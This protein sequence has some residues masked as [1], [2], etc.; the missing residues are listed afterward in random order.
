MEEEQNQQYL[1]DPNLT[2][3]MRIQIAIDEFYGFVKTF[4]GESEKVTK[5]KL[6]RNNILNMTDTYLKKFNNELI[7]EEF[8]ER[9]S[10]AK[11]KASN[12]GKVNKYKQF[13][14]ELRVVQEYKGIQQNIAEK[15]AEQLF[16]LFKDSEVLPDGGPATNDTN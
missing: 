12:N 16:D 8:R 10:D 7:L 9:L 2:D 3:E 1:A 5:M 15:L 11:K 6:M 13:M 4:D 14:N